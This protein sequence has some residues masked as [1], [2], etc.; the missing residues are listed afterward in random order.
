MVQGLDVFKQRF[1]NH[2]DHYILIGGTAC[3]LAMEDGG[4]DFRATRDLDIVL[5]IETLD[6]EFASDLWAFIKEAAYK[7]KSH[8]SGGVQFYRFT[9][10]KSNTYPIMLEL[11]SREP[12]ALKL[13]DDATLTPV[14]VDDPLS[15]L[16]A[17]LLNPDAYAF[18]KDGKTTI[19]SLS[20][21]QPSHIIP[22]KAQAYLDLSQSKQ[23]G[24]RIDSKDIKKHKNDVFRLLA[25]LTGDERIPLPK[26]MATCMTDFLRTIQ[27]E[28]ID[29]NILKPSGLTQAAA[30]R[31][32]AAI[33]A[34]E[35]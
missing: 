25:A 29:K 35:I 12:D 2:S 16:S 18:L 14:P 13:P 28:N 33:Y 20:T 27:T 9:H 23:D 4:F 21:L 1:A 15:S 17:I 34:I 6:D 24:Q 22:L 26:L 5:V 30:I 31:L 3:S 11:F 8:S 7:H 10:P 32:L 19:D